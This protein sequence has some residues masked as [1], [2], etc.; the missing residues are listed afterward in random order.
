MYFFAI[1]LSTI[2]SILS[3]KMD[4]VGITILQYLYMVSY[5]RRTQ[6]NT[7]KRIQ[8]KILPEIKNERDLAKFG[9]PIRSITHAFIFN[10]GTFLEP[11]HANKQ[12]QNQLLSKKDLAKTFSRGRKLGW[13][14]PNYDCPPQGASVY[15]FS[16]FG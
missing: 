16:N 10:F 12:T 8:P 11:P 6:P 7:K 13:T 1:L 4:A 15:P 3:Y 14:Q 9:L 2:L 5:K